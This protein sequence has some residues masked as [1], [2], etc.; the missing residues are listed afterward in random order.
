MKLKLKK[1]IDETSIKSNN[2]NNTNNTNNPDNTTSKKRNSLKSRS[3][4][5]IKSNSGKGGASKETSGGGLGPNKRP[6]PDVGVGVF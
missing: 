5:K 3:S 6:K 4:L 2:T 1:L